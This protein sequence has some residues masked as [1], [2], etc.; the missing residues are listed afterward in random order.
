MLS[1]IGRE[2]GA[3]L[4][5]IHKLAAFFDDVR[6]GFFKSPLEIGDAFAVAV[7]LIS[8]VG[9]RGAERQRVAAVSGVVDQGINHAVNAGAL[10]FAAGGQT[11]LRCRLDL[12]E[13]HV[14]R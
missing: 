7:G 11:F 9:Q 8:A 1:L 12:S 6:G 3:A 4:R 10:E 14:V 5:W 2:F 13:T